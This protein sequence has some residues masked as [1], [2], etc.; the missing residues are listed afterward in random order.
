MSTHGPWQKIYPFVYL[1]KLLCQDQLVDQHGGFAFSLYAPLYGGL[2]SIHGAYN[3][4]SLRCNQHKDT[5]LLALVQHLW[6]QLM[7]HSRIELN[8]T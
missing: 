5:R 4:A 3:V 6:D 1:A 8:I 7:L 2:T